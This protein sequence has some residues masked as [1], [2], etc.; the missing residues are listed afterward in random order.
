STVAEPTS[1]SDPPQNEPQDVKEPAQL[2]PDI[3]AIPKVLSQRT[4]PKDWPEPGRIALN[5]TDLHAANL[6]GGHL[7]E[8]NLG[9]AYVR[10]APPSAGPLERASLVDC[11]LQGALRKD[12]RLEGAGLLGAHREGAYLE[13]AHLE[14]AS[15]DA[16]HL[17]RADLSRAHL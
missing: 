3:Q 15:L 11:A 16:A 7:E 2:R 10:G 8:A 17:E 9:S 14:K 13:D 5:K 4:P 6:W 1:P 12:T